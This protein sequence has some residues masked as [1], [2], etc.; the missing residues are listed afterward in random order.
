MAGMREATHQSLDHVPSEHVI[1]CRAA[2]YADQ[3][4]VDFK[5]LCRFGNYLGGVVGDRPYGNDLDIFIP[6]LL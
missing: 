1:K 6:H 4:S 2:G 5:L 3:N